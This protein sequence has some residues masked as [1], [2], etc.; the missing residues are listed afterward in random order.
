MCSLKISPEHLNFGEIY[1]SAHRNIQP[2]S[3]AYRTLVVKNCNEFAIEISLDE[4]SNVSSV[5][6]PFK[7]C[8]TNFLSKNVS[9]NCQSGKSFVLNGNDVGEFYIFLYP[10]DNKYEKT[11]Q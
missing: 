1:Y 3:I 9:E 8:L 5:D 4:A 7:V 2:S 11:M 10:M 6:F